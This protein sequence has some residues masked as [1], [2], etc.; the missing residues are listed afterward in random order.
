MEAVELALESSRFMSPRNTTFRA[1]AVVVGGSAWPRQ[2]RA[3]I[4]IIK[5]KRVNTSLVVKFMQEKEERMSRESAGNF[6]VQHP[7]ILRAQKWDPNAIITY[8]RCILYGCNLRCRDHVAGG[9]AALRFELDLR[10]S[11][12]IRPTRRHSGL[13]WE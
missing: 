4:K 1:V 2:P 10:I 11:H 13:T 8:I 6:S 3:T 12:A 9:W 7:Q 5:I